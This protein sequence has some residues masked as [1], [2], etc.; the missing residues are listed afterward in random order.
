MKG[1]NE[2]VRTGG[3]NAFRENPERNWE[4]SRIEFDRKRIGA[5]TRSCGRFAHLSHGRRRGDLSSG[6]LCRTFDG[7]EQRPRL[8]AR[9]DRNA[10]ARRNGNEG[11]NVRFLNR[12]RER[13]AFREFRRQLLERNGYRH[14]DERNGD[15]PNELLVEFE[16]DRSGMQPIRFRIQPDRFVEYRELQPE[17]PSDRGRMEPNPPAQCHGDGFGFGRSLRILARHGG[18]HRMSPSGRKQREHRE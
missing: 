10:R 11:R 12:T 7:D 9:F 4:F 2:I 1:P 16:L 5:R 13:N 8:R 15:L 3:R 18:V 6:T 14:A 17:S